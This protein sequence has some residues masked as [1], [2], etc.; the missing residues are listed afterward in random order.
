MLRNGVNVGVKGDFGELKKLI[1]NL[2]YI[3][4][5]PG[6]TALNSVVAEQ[7]LKAVDRGFREQK[8]PY[9]NAWAPLKFRTGLILQDKGALRG[10]FSST[11]HADGFDISNSQPYAGTQNYGLVRLGRVVFPIPDEQAGKSFVSKGMGINRRSGGRALQRKAE[12]KRKWV[13]APNGVTIPP[14]VM[15]PEGML[16]DEWAKA[17]AKGIDSFMES[18]F[19][20]A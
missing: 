11:A 8:D 10:S 18:V 1:S 12:G 2:R 4:S 3:A 17:F 13:V 14:R 15:V 5:N 6:K 19:S 7:A 9:G 16:P 20:G